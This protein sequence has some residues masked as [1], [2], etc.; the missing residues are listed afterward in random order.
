MKPVAVLAGLREHG[1]ASPAG[2]AVIG[3]DDIP[4]ARLAT[5]PLTTVCYDL[6]GAARHRAETIVAG[7]TGRTTRPT[8]ISADPRVIRRSST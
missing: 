5:P 7:L 3:A 8:G 4:T 1:L 6:Y 2:L